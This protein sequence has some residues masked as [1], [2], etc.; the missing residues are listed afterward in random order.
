VYHSE[1]SFDWP[2]DWCLRER[3]QQDSPHHSRKNHDLRP[4]F[5]R[6][7]QLALFT[8]RFRVEGLLVHR[9]SCRIRK[10]NRESAYF[11]AQCS[12]R[13]CEVEHA[14]ICSEDASAASATS[15]EQEQTEVAGLRYDGGN[16]AVAKGT[17]WR[18]WELAHK[19]IQKQRKETPGP[20]P[21]ILEMEDDPLSKTQP[22]ANFHGRKPTGFFLTLQRTLEGKN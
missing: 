2:G 9:E 1:Q 21:W 10:A 15:K 22:E 18:K 16:V 12:G 7:E 8:P 4:Q 20:L 3:D 6:F 19:K 17:A 13:S 11:D 5:L 14:E